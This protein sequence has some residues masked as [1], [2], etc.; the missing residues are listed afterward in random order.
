VVAGKTKAQVFLVGEDGIQPK[1]VYQTRSPIVAALTTADRHQWA[2]LEETGRITV[3][4]V[5]E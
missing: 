5:E 3:W 4:P 2:L 1:G